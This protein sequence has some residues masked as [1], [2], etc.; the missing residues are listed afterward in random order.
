MSHRPKDLVI[1]SRRIDVDP[2]P[3][4]EKNHVWHQDG[5]VITH[6]MNAFQSLFP[7]GER[8]FI[9]TV[10]DSI[11]HYQSK[12]AD[13]PVLQQDIEVFIEQEGRHSMLHDKWTKALIATGYPKMN[14]YGEF[15]HHFRLWSRSHLDLMTRLSFTIASEQ[16]TAS[17]ARLFVQD[18]P[19][20]M[21]H[22]PP[23]FQK[24]FLYHIMEELEHKAVCFDIYQKLNG[25]YMRR[26]LGMLFITIDIW[27]NTFLRQR[28]LLRK[29]KKWDRQH[30]RECWE[31]YLGRNGLVKKL[32]P[33]VSAYMKPS[34]H[35]WETDER[36]MFEQQFGHRLA[37]LGIQGFQYTQNQGVIHT[38]EKPID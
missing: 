19:E 23:I 7:D 8:L 1:V 29:D 22:S 30:K 13:D 10:R 24:I 28:Y 4:L 32:L 18:F 12:I 37:Q 6:F 21:L 26:I 38:K 27:V 5:A 11:A 31:L 16:Y 34:F 15:L 25:G 17:L 35:P 14:S 9:D 20:M 33:R 36:G 2:L 3:Y